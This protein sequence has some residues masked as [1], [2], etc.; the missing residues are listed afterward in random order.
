M[1]FIN[2]LVGQ[3]DQAHGLDAQVEE[4]DAHVQAVSANPAN[5]AVLDALSLTDGVDVAVVA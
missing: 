5:P 4:L 1:I 2:L 3:L